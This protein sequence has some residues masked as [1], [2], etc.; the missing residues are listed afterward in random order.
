[1]TAS[2][3]LTT[4]GSLTLDI[5]GKPTL[6]GRRKPLALLAYLARRPGVR[7]RRLELATL[8]WPGADEPRAR[9]SLRQTLTELREAVNPGMGVTD[10]HVWVEPGALW[11][12]ANALA[13]AVTQNRPDEALKLWGGDFLPEAESIGDEDFR[14]WL[15]AEREDLRRRMASAATAEVQR[16][17]GLANWTDAAVTARQWTERSPHDERAVRRLVDV[18]VM[19]GRR[20]EAASEY[21][22]GAQRLQQAGLPLSAEFAALGAAT[23]R[24]EPDPKLS[25]F[26][27]LSPDMVGRAEAITV[28]QTSWRSAQR[29]E[30]ASIVI[31]GDTG[32][33]KSRL[34]EE[35]VRI[36]RRD[37]DRAIVFHTRAFEPESEVPYA[38]VRHLFA[39]LARAAGLSTSPPAV[40]QTLARWIPE[41]GEVF[42]HLSGEGS[43]SMPEAIARAIADVGEEAPI[44]IAVDDAH[45]ADRESHTVLEALSRRPP[46]H[47][48]IVCSVPGE[49]PRH[50]AGS[51]ITLSN[52]DLAGVEQLVASMAEFRPGDR[53]AL[54]NR[55]MTETRGNPLAVVE[56]VRALAEQGAIGPAP[57]GSWTIRNLKEDAPLPVPVS[58]RDAALARTRELGADA[59]AVLE[60]AVVVGRELDPEMLLA[61][62]GFGSERLERALEDLLGRRL[63][64]AAP[65]GSSRLE[66]A[67]EHLRR[68]VYESLSP[69]RRSEWEQR[70]TRHKNGSMG[71]RP[72]RGLLVALTAAAAIILVALGWRWYRSRKPATS[73]TTA[74]R[75][76]SAAGGDTVFGFQATAGSL[77]WVQTR[78][79]EALQGYAEAERLFGAHEVPE[80]IQAYR[81]ATRKD[82]AL[83]V[84]W[85]R[86][87]ESGLW[88]LRS[89]VARVGAD[90]ALHYVSGINPTEVVH[91]RAFRN[92]AVGNIQEAE[93]QLRGEIAVFP[94]R[95]ESRYLLADLLYHFY[96]LKGTSSREARLLFEGLRRDQPGD[97][98]PLVHLWDIAVI[99]GR[100]ATAAALRDTI[101]QLAPA[102][103]LFDGYDAIT[104]FASADSAGRR[105][106]L[107]SLSGRDQWTLANVVR[108]YANL[109][110][111][112]DGAMELSGLLLAPDR[113][114]EVRATGHLFR[115]MALLGQGRFGRAREEAERAA[116]LSPVAEYQW[117]SL[118]LGPGLPPTGAVE[119]ERRRLRE[120]LARSGG[121]PLVPLSAPYYPWT[122]FDKRDAEDIFPYLRGR[123]A[124]EISDTASAMT[125]LGTLQDTVAVSGELRPVLAKSLHAAMAVQRGDTDAAIRL[126]HSALATR[127]VDHSMMSV[128]VAQPSE[129]YA[130]GQ[131]L[132]RAGRQDEAKGWL[133]GIGEGSIFDLAYLAPA[134]YLLA[135]LLESE[136]DGSGAREVYQRVA[137]LYRNADPEFQSLAV[138]ARER[139]QALAK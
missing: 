41:I 63:L 116:S 77:A 69:F 52:L 10:Q 72:G 91:Y 1:L 125:W 96:W 136:G 32:S 2:A 29:G 38:L 137:V 118:V 139:A 74:V 106:I 87:G 107:D 131:W 12:D 37:G 109:T 48:L 28:L 86:I 132:I 44:V 123:L 122:D 103:D 21:A 115:S 33:G 13:E 71:R 66:F 11:V 127:P 83:A 75:I 110:R 16:L 49:S 31:Q 105:A 102:A 35:L 45:L 34:L 138:R 26:A 27:L 22:A 42:P 133:G 65:D 124:L 82:T 90:S 20:T 53:R 30:P 129:R 15:E 14:I 40:L 70:L 92:F 85:Y 62:T 108:R 94:R 68:G 73:D 117:A 97:W 23:T 60:A 93:S 84:A 6:S 134:A 18:L 78:S 88:L 59:R 104:A 80:A 54:V 100:I 19:A 58:L 46:V 4:L 36:V 64:R 47:T 98:R 111:D 25:V 24:P 67:H 79:F 5:D 57:D 119:A 17:V 113:P 120:T 9:Q 81:L 8:F 135:E 50:F 55:L 95:T 89:D 76:I 112:A 39:T 61:L 130:M 3:R 126:L 56:I 43:V 51:R 128:F 99:D 114:P 101:H 7:V 121:I